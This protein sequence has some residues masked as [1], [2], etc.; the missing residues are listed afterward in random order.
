M[1]L[2]KSILDFI[3]ALRCSLD[4]YDRGLWTLDI[5]YFIPDYF[6]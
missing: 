2:L 6:R 4:C 3:L 1:D 5:W